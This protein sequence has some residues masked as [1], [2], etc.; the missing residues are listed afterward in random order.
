MI[1]IWKQGLCI[2]KCR[3]LLVKIIFI[4]NM[5]SVWMITFQYIAFRS[6]DNFS[7]TTRF[8]HIFH[9]FPIFFFWLVSHDLPYQKFMISQKNSNKKLLPSKHSH[10]SNCYWTQ[11]HKQLVHKGTLNHLAKLA[12]FLCEIKLN[13]L[14]NFIQY[15]VIFYFKH[16]I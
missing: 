1:N 5:F 11:T 4:F 9:T 7:T 10:L 8:Y 14:W 3:F 6:N 12:N 16:E 13:L 2:L 15:W